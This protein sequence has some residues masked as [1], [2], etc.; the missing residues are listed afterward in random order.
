VVDALG[1]YNTGRCGG[2]D[3]YAERVLRERDDLLRAVGLD[4]RQASNP[5]PR[6]SLATT[7]APSAL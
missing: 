2:N 3:A 6:T 7:A 5:P 4:L 1:A